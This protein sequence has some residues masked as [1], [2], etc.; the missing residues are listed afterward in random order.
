MSE[1]IQHPNGLVESALTLLEGEHAKAQALSSAVQELVACL[2]ATSKDPRL[3]RLEELIG[4]WRQHTTSLTRLLTEEFLLRLPSGTAATT[5]TGHRR[6]AVAAPLLAVQPFTITAGSDALLG[7]LMAQTGAERGFVLFWNP[8]TTEADVSAAR[9]FQTKVFSTE[10]YQCSRTL[11]R[12]ALAG[13]PLRLEDASGHPHFCEAQ[14]VMDFQIRSVMAVPLA[15][16]HRPIGAI[17]LEHNSRPGAFTTDDLSLAEDAARMFLF[18]L[19]QARL[20]PAPPPEARVFLDAARAPTEIVGRDPAVLALLD[21][22][23]RI[24]DSPA[25]VLIE[26]ESG[27]GKDLVARAL[28][29]QSRR[30]NKPFGIINCAAI[31]ENLLESELFGREK[32]AY[33]GATPHIGQVEEADGGTVFFDEIGELSLPLQ[34]KLLRFLQAGEFRRLG[35]TRTRHADVRV[36]AATSRDLQR[37]MTDGRFLEALYF[38][39]KVIPIRMPKLSAR[40]GDIPLL[41]EHFR[42]KFADSYRCP[43]TMD[44]DVIAVLRE[45]PFPGNVRELENLVER[46]VALSTDGR[47]GLGDLPKEVFQSTSGRISLGPAPTGA[48]STIPPRSLAEVRQQ[49]AALKAMLDEQEQRLAS[50]T[51]AECGGDIRQAAARLGIHWATLYKLLKRRPA[52][53]RED[54]GPAAVSA[55]PLGS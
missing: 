40:S 54:P 7:S 35:D 16:E 17:Y 55:K 14:S 31:P 6:W 22:V 26:G 36:V 12:R 15:D 51:V 33:T 37:M 43:V 30:R 5:D 18:I 3:G 39:L 13:E 19:R 25:A 8:E 21:L 41:I 34:S 48:E 53:T 11:L 46:L 29:F 9:N 52:E 50:R 4:E 20:L 23:R 47:I 24:A 1:R 10:E 28:H 49:R 27:T 45:Y 2:R 44:P 38:R 42:A 32:G